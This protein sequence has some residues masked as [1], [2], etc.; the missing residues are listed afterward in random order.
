[1]KK[2]TIGIQTHAVRE[3]FS[4]NPAETLQRIKA[5]GYEGI[6]TTWSALEG[7]KGGPCSDPEYFLGLLE[8]NGLQCFSVMLSWGGQVKEKLDGILDYCKKIKC[9]TIV[10]GGGVAQLDY[11]E[12][13]ESRLTILE[14]VKAVA[15]K[16]RAA[17][18]R[19]GFHNHDCDHLTTVDGS[20]TV[21]DFLFE[22][23]GDDYMLMI[24]TG[25]TQGGDADPIEL[26]KKYP[27]RTQIAHFKGYS[28]EKKYLTPVWE[29]EIDS[30]ELIRTLV[31]DGDAE[32]F[33]IEFGA[34]GEYI[35][36]ERAERSYQWLAAKL[37]EKGLI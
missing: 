15:A 28:S 20:K 23:T 31:E 33:S 35:P 18:F 7:A 13:E 21:F 27:H 1:M 26:V 16:I 29:A 22:N 34:R 25:N 37:K 10:L 17:G 3:D 32:I 36:F 30:D 5:L 14:E 24:D 8:Q 4:A 12:T 9:E 2:I 11:G 6:E 19:T